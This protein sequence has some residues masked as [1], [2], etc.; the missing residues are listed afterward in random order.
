MGG[1]RR[2]PFSRG[3]QGCQSRRGTPERQALA[4]DAVLDR[5]GWTELLACWLHRGVA[6]SGGDM[7]GEE[8][9]GSG[10]DGCLAVAWLVP[11]CTTQPALPKPL[12]VGLRRAG[13]AGPTRGCRPATACF[14]GEGSCLAHGR[15]SETRRSAS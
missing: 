10:V 3:R 12:L 4:G 13:S 6:V 14:A 1:R 5:R 15:E 7:G 9:R 2:C 11:G 8:G